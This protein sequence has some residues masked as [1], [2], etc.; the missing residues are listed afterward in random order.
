VNF[1]TVIWDYYKENALNTLT[2]DGV[3]NTNLS[4]E[5]KPVNFSG[6]IRIEPIIVEGLPSIQVSGLNAYE[7]DQNISVL[8]TDLVPT[9][10]GETRTQ[11]FITNNT[12]VIG[13]VN[14]PTTINPTS[15]VTNNTM[16]FEEVFRSLG[17][18]QLQDKE[19]IRNLIIEFKEG[20]KT[21]SA[22]INRSRFGMINQKL[23]NSLEILNL[24]ISATGKFYTDF[25]IT[26]S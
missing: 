22:E 5:S 2:I 19:E 16:G 7:S 14:A 26:G 23:K 8:G 25:L 17:T 13:A 15:T 20:I 12:I 1:P 4:S 10:T 9:I 3:V 21:D 11:Q 24:F 18:S 6:Q